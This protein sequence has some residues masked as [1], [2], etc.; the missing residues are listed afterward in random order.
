ME[1]TTNDKNSMNR[2]EFLEFFFQPFSSLKRIA[3][4]A[5]G[6]RPLQ[7][8]DTPFLVRD[9][10]I[11]TASSISCTSSQTNRIPQSRNEATPI[12][13]TLKEKVMEFSWEDLK[14]KTKVEVFT[15]ELAKNYISL[16]GTTRLKETDLIG[17]GK[18]DFYYSLAEYENAVRE[19]VPDYSTGSTEWGYTHYDTNHLY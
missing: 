6:G 11:F 3:Q 7:R 13:K 19:V 17:S 16:T 5:A 18:T 12:V 2:R 10:L 15:Q 8:K 1:N 14:D 4:A 9:A